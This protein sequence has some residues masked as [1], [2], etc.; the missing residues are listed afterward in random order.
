MSPKAKNH[1]PLPGSFE[2]VLTAIADEQRPAE[3]SFTARPFLKWVG[4]KRSIVP[5]L[6]AEFPASYTS[7]HEPFLGGGA[8]YFAA[9]PDKAV[10][11]PPPGRLSARNQISYQ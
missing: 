6:L 10:N 2:D 1:E 8:L 3:S 5:A 7:Y 9:K 11:P 4:G